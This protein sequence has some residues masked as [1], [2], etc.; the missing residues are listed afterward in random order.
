[1]KKTL[2]RLLPL[3]ILSALFVLVTASAVRAASTAS[4]AAT[5][6]LQNISI[7]VGDGSISYGTIAANTSK[8]TITSDLNDTQVATNNGNVTEKIN[9]KGMN[10]SAWTLAGSPGVDQYVHK[11][12]TTSCSTPPTNFTALTTNYQTAAATVSASG[13]VSIDLQLTTPTS[14][15]VFTQQAVDLTVMAEAV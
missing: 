2:Y 1:M 12:C 9:I 4:V 8:S 11:Y 5:V 7:S 14:S 3:V 13:T 15:T 10:S 6:T